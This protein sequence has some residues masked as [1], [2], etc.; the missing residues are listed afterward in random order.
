MIKKRETIVITIT[1]LLVLIGMIVTPENA[2]SE[3]FKEPTVTEKTLI[4]ELTYGEFSKET[5]EV[6]INETSTTYSLAEEFSSKDVSTKNTSAN[7]VENTSVVDTSKEEISIEETTTEKKTEDSTKSSSNFTKNKSTEKVSSQETTSEKLTTKKVISNN[8]S[9]SDYEFEL[10][11]KIVEHEVGKWPS[12]FPGYDFD[13]IQKC[14]AKIVINRIQSSKFPNSILEVLC[15]PGHFMSIEELDKCPTMGENTRNNLLSVIYGEDDISDT[16]VFEMSF[17]SPDMAA[18][19]RSMESMVG[20]V[21]IYYT[22]ITAD[23]R[24]LIYASSR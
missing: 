18:N 17:T 13:Y 10:L 3:T 24:Y 6:S 12:Y 8:I 2:E 5:K 7:K 9:Y 15:Q 22:A 11:G 20:P 4:E 1:F 23:N 19:Q 21:S 16:I 14:M